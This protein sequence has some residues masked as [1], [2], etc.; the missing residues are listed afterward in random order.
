MKTASKN[1]PKPRGK[2]RFISSIIYYTYNV[3]IV[4]NVNDNLITV[5]SM[6]FAQ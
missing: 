5:F 6:Y 4:F 3:S 2:Y 1:I